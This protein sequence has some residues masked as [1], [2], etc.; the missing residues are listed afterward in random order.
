MYIS[1]YLKINAGEGINKMKDT[2]ISRKK[3][4]ALGVFYTKV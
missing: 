3:V 4:G 1:K 2:Q